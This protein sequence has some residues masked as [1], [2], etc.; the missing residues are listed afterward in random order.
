MTVSNKILPLL[1][2]AALLTAGCS[3]PAGDYLFVSAETARAH[4]GNYVFQLPLDSLHTYTTALA[5]RIVTNRIP[6]TEIDLDIHVTE[7]DGTTSIERLTLPLKETPGVTVIAG[8][9]PV[10]DFRWPWHTRRV[11][12]AKA[13]NW[14]VRI[15]P[16]EPASA[17]ALYGIGLSYEGTPWEKE[18]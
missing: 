14:Q 7:P 8:N 10:A 18:N 4:D 6:D 2:L 1:L 9:G 3:K 15:T 13:G 16:T 11:T 17:A 5:A 12:G